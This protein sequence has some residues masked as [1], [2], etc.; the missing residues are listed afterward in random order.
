MNNRRFLRLIVVTSL[1]AVV[2]LSC[3]SI[4]FLSPYFTNLIVNNAESQAVK[5]G[6]HLSESFLDMDKVTRELPSDFVE[7]V[8]RTVAD[9]GLIKIK[10]F[11]PDGETVY[12][13]SEK[14]IGVINE[15]DYFHNIV[16]KGGVL[17]RWSIGTPSPLK[18]KW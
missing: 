8:S 7:M 11:A 12:S 2:S 5:V 14:D 3:F 16:A 1:I 17:P 15:R 10:V 18:T 9:F 4:F 13:T 6:R